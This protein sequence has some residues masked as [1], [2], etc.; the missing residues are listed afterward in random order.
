VGANIG[1]FSLLAARHCPGGKII[2]L[3]PVSNSYK[4]LTENIALNQFTNIEMLN[5]AAGD[6]EESR[7]IYLSADDN[8]G[9]A[10]FNQPYNYS[11]KTELVKVTKLDHLAADLKLTRVDAVKIDVE[12]N[13]LAVLKGMKHIM[14]GFKPAILLELNPHTLSRSGVQPADVLDYAASLSYNAYRIT[15]NTAISA[16]ANENISDT[17]DVLLLHKTKKG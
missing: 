5:L 15:D 10:S 3:E 7:I 4:A 11:G 14:E 9:M 6:T 13:E 16:I 2:S 1:Y 8:T 12:G 17:T